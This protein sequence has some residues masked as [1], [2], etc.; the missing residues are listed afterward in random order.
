MRCIDGHPLSGAILADSMGLGKTLQ[1]CFLMARSRRKNILLL[2]LYLGMMIKSFRIPCGA[3]HHTSVD[4][5]PAESP[6]K[7]ARKEGSYRLP[8]K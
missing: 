6:W 3:G 7:S 2:F 8:S 4:S 5:P 1:V